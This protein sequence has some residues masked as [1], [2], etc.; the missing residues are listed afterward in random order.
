MI[1]SICSNS[2]FKSLLE[3]NLV[4]L[5]ST[6]LIGIFDSSIPYAKIERTSSAV[7]E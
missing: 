3:E 2:L 4:I 1:Q 5:T 6:I 7:I